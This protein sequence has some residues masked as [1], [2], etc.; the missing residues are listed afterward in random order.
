MDE[1]LKKLSDTSG[2]SGNENLIRA[3][4]KEEAEK[5]CEVKTDNLGNV[6]AYKKGTV[7][8]KKIMLAA[9]M[10]EVGLMASYI[11]DSG[12]IRFKAV[13]GIDPRV[14]L[15]KRVVVGKNRIPGIIG[16][17]AIHLQSP[18]E[19]GNVIPMT[20]LYIDVGASSKEDTGV[21]IGDYISF[22]T[23]AEEFGDNKIKGKALDDRLGVRA[24]LE[25]MKEEYKDDVYFCFTVQEEIGTR[26]AG[27]AA[28]TVMPDIAIVLEAT[29]AA[30][31]PDTEEC[32]KVT[33]LGNGPAIS[34]AD[35][36]TVYDRELIAAIMEAG[37]KEEIPY[38]V[39]RAEYGANDAGVIH[40][41]REGVKTAAISVPTRYIH[42]PVSVADIR[43]YENMTALVRAYLKNR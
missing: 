26:G 1:L 5:Y 10:D 32:D 35:Y 33:V 42:S 19:R 4:V 23:K 17:K 9:H 15:A 30:D 20:S 7:G 21:K 41:S 8:E 13:G 31:V 22:I 43:D 27:V 12:Y 25:L 37:D 34:F 14:L 40:L 29:T 28:F 3:I 24:L 18:G 2:V 39:K 6:I 38:Q 36:G 11:D 16:V